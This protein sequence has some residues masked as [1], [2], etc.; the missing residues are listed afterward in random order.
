MSLHTQVVM[1]FYRQFLTRGSFQKGFLLKERICFTQDG[2]KKCKMAFPGHVFIH[3]TDGWMT[4]NFT[5]FST[6]Q[7][8]ERFIMKA[9]CYGTPITVEK[10][11]PQ[12]G[13]Y[14]G[15]ARSVGQRL[16]H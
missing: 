4:C 11:L 10:I 7:A 1:K 2:G 13:I 6:Y 14:L 5:S 9:V 3:L 16:T 8:D 15:T 12:A